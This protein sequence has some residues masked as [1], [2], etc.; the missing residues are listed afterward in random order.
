MTHFLEVGALRE[1]LHEIQEN[2]QWLRRL[3]SMPP[4]QRTALEQT[5]VQQGDMTTYNDDVRA[6]LGA[7][8][9]QTEELVLFLDQFESHPIIYTGEGST[10]EVLAMLERLISQNKGGSGGA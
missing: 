2:A 3:L 5:R 10:A 9:M 4:E 6:A 8:L 1:A 7:V